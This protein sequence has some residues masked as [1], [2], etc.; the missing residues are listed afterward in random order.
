MSEETIDVISEIA[1]ERQHQCSLGYDEEH[2]DT[3]N[4]NELSDAAVCYVYAEEKD[5]LTDCVW[6]WETEFW[7]PKT[8]REN[9][10][11]AAALIVAEI[12]RMDRK[13]A[14]R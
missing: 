14:V 12:E 1:A 5:R 10:I 11:R 9:L 8:K 13:D 2:D 6:P 3:Y 4:N 7:N